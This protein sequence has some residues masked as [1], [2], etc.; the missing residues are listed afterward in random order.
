VG[1]HCGAAALSVT[2]R[3]LER[4]RVCPHTARLECTQSLVLLICAASMAGAAP[5]PA[6]LLPVMADLSENWS[7]P[8]E[9]ARSLAIVQRLKFNQSQQ[10]SAATARHATAEDLVASMKLKVDAPE[11]TDELGALGAVIF[12]RVLQDSLK[13]LLLPQTAGAGS[14]AG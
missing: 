7:S 13:R 9:K 10:R 2:G 12:A 6:F 3:V 11:Q 4:S 5:L 1:L 8:D 14:A